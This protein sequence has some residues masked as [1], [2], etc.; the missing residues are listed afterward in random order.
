MADEQPTPA[1]PTP[2]PKYPRLVKAAPWILWAI[3]TAIAL[4]LGVQPPPLPVP[5]PVPVPPAVLPDEGEVETFG[6]VPDPESIARSADPAKTTQ[7][8][9]TPAGKAALG[10][11]PAFLW[12]PVVQVYGRPTW[13]DQRDVGCCVGC[14]FKHAVD[15]VQAVQIVAGRRPGEFKPVSVESIYGASR[16]EVGGGR[17][18]GDGSVGAWAKEA[19]QEYGVLPMERFANG[20]DLSEFS[21]ARARQW[22]RSGIP[23]DLEPVAREHP[24]RGAALVKSWTDVKR[25]V[26]QG[27]PVAVCSDQGFRMDRNAQ[28]VARPSGR[29]MHAMCVCGVA[30]IGGRECGFVLNSWGDRAHTGGR[31]PDDMPDAGFW[32]EAAVIDRMVRQGDSFALSDVVGFPARKLD[33]FTRREGDRDPLRLRPADPVADRL[34]LAW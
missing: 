8:D 26:Q 31:W 24:V 11:E 28:G 20:V 29:W 14:G 13:V 16:V 15:I 7:F 19:V 34:A 17:I 27:Y 33:W 5:V 30:T 9:A 23:D 4:Y 25:A 10:D 2:A 22:G 12:R 21:P 18:S 32:A 6:W 1:P 3:S